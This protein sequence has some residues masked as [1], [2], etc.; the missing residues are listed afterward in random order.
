M[1]GEQH[2][3]TTATPRTR[4]IAVA[5]RITGSARR[6]TLRLPI[7]RPWAKAFTRVFT[8]ATGPPQPA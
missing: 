3:A 8:A 7:R 2:A 4:I 5:A 6:A 1:A